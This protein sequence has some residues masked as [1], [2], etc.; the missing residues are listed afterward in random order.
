M[1]NR[2]QKEEK[3]RKEGLTSQ[4]GANKLIQKR[5]QVQKKWHKSLLKLE[6]LDKRLGREKRKKSKKDKNEK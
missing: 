3:K 4:K 1:R 6:R 2:G 5:I